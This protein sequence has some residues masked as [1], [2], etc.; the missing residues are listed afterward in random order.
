MVYLSPGFERIW[1]V[2]ADTFYANPLRW[3]DFI[4][5]EDRERVRVAFDALAH[6]TPSVDVENGGYRMAWVG[7]AQDDAARSITPM[8]HAGAEDGYLSEIKASWNEGEKH[9]IGP[10]GQVI[11]SGQPV[12][13]EDL[14]QDPGFAH[15][16][17]PA[18]RRGYRGYIVLP[19]RD[20][21]HIRVAGALYLRGKAH[22]R[23][24]ARAPAADGRRCGVRHRQPARAAGAAPPPVSGGHRG[25]G[26]VA[27]HRH[28][29][30]PGGVRVWLMVSMATLI[31]ARILLVGDAQ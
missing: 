8:G 29:V 2:S 15:W 21:T 9:G 22:E 28:E 1:G 26:R 4:V 20:S 25:C 14:E 11:R 19:L 13:C 24:G 18:R 31:R 6:D 27:C 12:V 30:L 7:Y 5:A 23:R 3:T 10:A 16:L 17:E